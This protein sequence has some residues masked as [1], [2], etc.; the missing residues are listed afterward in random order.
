MPAETQEWAVYVAHER[1]RCPGLRRTADDRHVPCMTEVGQVPA[2]SVARVRPIG[3]RTEPGSST[4]GC[5][6]CGC[7]YELL[8]QQ[9]VAA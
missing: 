7:R 9:S 2:G 4:H 6:R 1:I 8:T 3:G 5:K